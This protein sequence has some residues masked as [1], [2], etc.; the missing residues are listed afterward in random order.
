[1]LAKTM[2]YQMISWTILHRSTAFVQVRV[3]RRGDDQKY[4][5]HV[6]ATGTECDLALLCVDDAA[7][8]E[9]ICPMELGPMPYLQEHVAVVGFAPCCIASTFWLRALAVTTAC[10][11]TNV[12]QSLI[13]PDNRGAEGTSLP[14]KHVCRPSSIP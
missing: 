14:F 8:W 10:F 7:F 12:A 9:G 11:P 5:A 2:S 6:L 3:K 13:R 4:L 1:M